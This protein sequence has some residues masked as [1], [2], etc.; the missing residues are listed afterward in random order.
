[1]AYDY[2]V[3]VFTHDCLLSPFGLPLPAPFMADPEKV[4]HGR[5]RKKAWHIFLQM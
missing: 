4:W 1:V 5:L 3:A 2:P